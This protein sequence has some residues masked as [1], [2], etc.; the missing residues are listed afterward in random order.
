MY[1]LPKSS[2]YS[3]F[4]SSGCLYRTS[5]LLTCLPV[6]RQKYSPEYKS[7]N[8]IQFWHASSVLLSYVV[9]CCDLTFR[10]ESG[11]IP[12]LEHLHIIKVLMHAN[13]TIMFKD[14]RC[15]L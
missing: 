8:Q 11:V 4:F 1:F 10:A 12:I 7:F 13:A 2:E 3:C 15:S 6:K 14:Y 5:V 9:L